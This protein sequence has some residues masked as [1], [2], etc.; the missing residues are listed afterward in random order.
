MVQVKKD[1][2][3]DAVL[4]SASKLFEKKGYP[5]TTIKQIAAGADTVS[6]NVYVYFKSKF[7]IAVAIYQPW[8]EAEIHQLEAD[9]MEV[10]D[11]EK[12]LHM[13]INR[14]W[15]DIPAKRNGFARNYIQ[16]VSTLAS[17]ERYSPNLLLFMEQRIAALI[18]TCLPPERRAKGEWESVSRILLMAF[19]GFVINRRLQS[20]YE[21]HEKVVSAAVRLLTGRWPSAPQ[22]VQERGIHRSGIQ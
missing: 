7:D 4:A 15:C 20:K 16:A 2:V 8:L 1:A 6:S 3:R 22:K 17:G 9:V 21:D 14:L 5:A 19:D 12:R 10:P 11:P 18:L 13:I